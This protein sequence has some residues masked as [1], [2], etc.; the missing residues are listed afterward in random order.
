MGSSYRILLSEEKTK[1]ITKGLYSIS[2]NPLYIGSYISFIGIF[3]LI[4][5]Y[6]YI[7][8]III[9]LINNHFRILEEEKNLLE[10]YKE[11]YEEYRKK[12][13]GYFIWI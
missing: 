8:S 13:G 12:V 9:L 10:V 3:L 7:I 1:L 6:S 4:P 2:R 11:E 5:S